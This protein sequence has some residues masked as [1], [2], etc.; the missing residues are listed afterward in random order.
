M[1]D[2]LLES[3]DMASPPVDRDHDQRPVVPQ[4]S[5]RVMTVIHSFTPGGV[6]RVALRLN[7][8]LRKIGKHAVVVVGRDDGCASEASDGAACLVIPNARGIGSRTQLLWMIRHLPRL[9]AS[10]RPDV[11][12]CPGNT[13]SS[14]GVAM[15]LLLGRRCP[16]IVTKVSNDLRRQDMPRPIRFLYHRWLRLQGRLLGEFVAMAPAMVPEIVAHMGV[17]AARVRV[18]H[19]PVLR[20]EELESFITLPRVA[21]RRGRR[22]LAVAR[23]APQKNLALLLAAFA[24]IAAPADR[25]TILGE[26]AERDGLEALAQS[27]GIASKVAMPGHVADVRPWMAE[28]DILCLSSDFEGV[29]AVLIEGIAA[30]LTVV[31]TDSSAAISDLIGD[32]AFGTLVPVGD[33]DAFAA[34]MRRAPAPARRPSDAAIRHVRAFTIESGAREYAALFAELAAS[35]VHGISA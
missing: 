21:A 16:P 31:T 24:R 12:F 26:G 34:A 14:V 23:L 3:P 27:L 25:L 19:D 18:I 20:E 17:P 32:G 4:P 5:F 28:A 8:A 29:P 1:L 30:G 33:V 11:L 10:Q 13:Y 35:A 6:E 22:Y 15:K 2:P 7:A 9:I